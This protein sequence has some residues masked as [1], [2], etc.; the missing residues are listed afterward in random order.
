LFAINL[1]KVFCLDDQRGQHFDFRERR[2]EFEWAGLSSGIRP[3]G[4]RP[5]TM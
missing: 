2:G 5:V 1:A 4:G 3:A